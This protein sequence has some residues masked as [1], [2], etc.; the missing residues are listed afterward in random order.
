MSKTKNLSTTSTGSV[1]GTNLHWE[2]IEKKGY[3]EGKA[4][5]NKKYSVKRELLK[6]WKDSYCG[7]RYKIITI[8]LRSVGMRDSDIFI[9]LTSDPYSLIIKLICAE[10]KLDYQEVLNTLKR[11]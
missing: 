3:T 7:E 1:K 9:A 6:L 8:Q 2:E 5:Y 11:L 10:Y 4:H